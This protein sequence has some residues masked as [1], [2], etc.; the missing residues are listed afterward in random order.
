MPAKWKRLAGVPQQTGQIQAVQ[1]K[2]HVTVFMRTSSAPGAGTEKIKTAFSE[3]AAATRDE[4][5][6]L[7]RNANMQGCMKSKGLKD[8]IHVKKSRGKYGLRGKVYVN[9][10]LEDQAP[11]GH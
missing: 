1:A 9:G 6:R 3:C 2:K 7:K 10:K 11:A 4:P 8:N 5:N